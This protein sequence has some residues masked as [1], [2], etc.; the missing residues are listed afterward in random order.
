MTIPLSKTTSWIGRLPGPLGWKATIRAQVAIHAPPSG[1]RK[2]FGICN[3]SPSRRPSPL[4]P[5]FDTARYC[6]SKMVVHSR[7]PHAFSTDIPRY[8]L[9][10]PTGSNWS[11]PAS[12]SCPMNIQ[13]CIQHVMSCNTFWWDIL[14]IYHTLT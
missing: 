14:F 2:I 13:I 10:K 6:P 3:K 12:S 7:W 1:S 8:S 4:Y 9:P 5:T 11:L